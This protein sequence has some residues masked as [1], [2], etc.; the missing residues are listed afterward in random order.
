MPDDMNP[1]T[2]TSG[3]AAMADH[4]VSGSAALAQLRAYI[5]DRA[6][7]PGE[8]LPPER[9]LCLDL[10][11]NRAELR[12]ALQVLESENR[13]WRHVG[14]GT[15][16]TDVDP[17][18]AQAD[19]FGQLAQ[20]VSP[21]DVLRARAAL[22]PAIAREAALHASA[23]AIA[24]L[25]LNV[26]RAVQAATWREYEALDNEFHR[27]IAESSG[28]TTL[29][30][31]FD[32]L[33]LLRRMVSWGRM[34][35]TGARPPAEHSSFAEHARIVDQISVRDPEAAQIAMRAHIRS[36]ENRLLG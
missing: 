15:F 32:Q 31:L 12:R 29:L 28:S 33:N 11:L 9:V 21:A 27:Q 23:S 17:G 6:F 5:A 10:G 8:R 20:Q 34:V 4:G 25:R 13:L 19:A 36:V 26:D 1:P 14:K 24:K 30:A 18:A 2:D 7:K 16:L 35:R 3:T 22:E